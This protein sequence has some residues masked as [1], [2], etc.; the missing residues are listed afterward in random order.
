MSESRPTKEIR[1][2]SGLIRALRETFGTEWESLLTQSGSYVDTDG[3]W[4]LKAKFWDT[5]DLTAFFLSYDANKFP[6]IE[7]MNIQFTAILSPKNSA[8]I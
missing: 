4:S 7:V 2:T 6:S 5:E 8:S 1:L 3:D